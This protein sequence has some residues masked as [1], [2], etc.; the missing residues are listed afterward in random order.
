MDSHAS[1]FARVT[2]DGRDKP[3]DL[4]CFTKPTDSG[5]RLMILEVGVPKSDQKTA[6]KQQASLGIEAADF[7]VSMLPDNKYGSV[8]II[9][10]MGFLL[11]YELQSGKRIFGER[12]SQYTMFAS[13]EHLG[14]E[15]GIM[16]IDQ[17]GRVAHLH[18]D[19]AK[20]ITYITGTLKDL[21]LGIDMARRYK[22]EAG[23][24]GIFQEQ[25]QSLLQAGQHQEAMQ[26]AATSPGGTLRTLE[27]INAFKQIGRAV[28]Q[29]C[30][31]RS[32]MPSSA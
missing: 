32:R 30:R 1:C 17:S 12:V 11:L 23:A 2:L 4:F 28:Q 21:T 29:E 19:P 13:V 20:V 7:P 5:M 6:F 31:D 16:T 18:I 27:T 15:G 10:K 14:D 3:S 22:L 25:F 9:T 26:L 24:G 8:F